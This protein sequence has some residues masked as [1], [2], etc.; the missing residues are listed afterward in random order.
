[1]SAV[2]AAPFCRCSGKACVGRKSVVFGAR[3]APGP[4]SFTK[5]IQ[6]LGKFPMGMQRGSTELLHRREA[7][8][9]CRVGAHKG[10]TMKS[11]EVCL[12]PNNK[13]GCLA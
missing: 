6:S 5:M 2:T 4:G 8:V 13:R 11:L 1:M 7:L 3:N 9:K 10:V 12:S